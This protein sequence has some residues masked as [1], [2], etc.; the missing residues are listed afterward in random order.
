MNNKKTVFVTG[1]SRGIGKSIAIKF[2][3]S[4]YNVAIGY[5]ENKSLA[6]ELARKYDT[7]GVKVDIS[8]RRSIQNALQEAKKYFNKEVD[9]LINNAA[10]AQEKPFETITDGDWDKMMEVNLRGPFVFCQEVLPYMRNQK[11]GR[12]VNIS[13]IGGVWGGFNQVHYAAAKAGLIN[14]TKSLARIYSKDGIT[15][16]AV[17]PGL[18]A[19][20]MSQNELDTEAG[21]KKVAD[22]PIGRIASPE[23]VSNVVAFLCSDAASY[24]TGQT[25]HVNGGMYFG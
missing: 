25:I 20:D 13:S 11:W 10:I 21:K 18:V 9:I 6:D 12:I 7:I 2:L 1:A 4:G 14:L 23:E 16:N 5:L 22:I 15:V 24:I 17:A 3:E 8:S 19:T